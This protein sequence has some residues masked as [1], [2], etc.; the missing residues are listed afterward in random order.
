MEEHL[1]TKEHL[2]QAFAQAYEKLI[3]TV[4]LSEQ[5]GVNRTPGSWGP[6]EI[7][8]HLIG[9]E[10]MASV[11]NPRTL[12][13]MPPAEFTDPTQA[14]AMNDAINAACITLVGEQ[15]RA[16]LCAMLRQAYQRNVEMLRSLED[17]FFQPDAYVHRWTQAVIEH[18]QEHVEQLV[19][20]HP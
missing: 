20:S 7:V 10:V 11:C 1:M 14:T 15:S 16:P 4:S 17:R 19:L 18:C 13:D 3:T 6:R 5:R 8:A 9:W 2:L 12:A